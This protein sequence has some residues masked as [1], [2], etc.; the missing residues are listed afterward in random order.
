MNETPNA[1]VKRHS[2]FQFLRIFQQFNSLA[3]YFV[4]KVTAEEYDILETR[5]LLARR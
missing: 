4:T 1:S 5:I 2:G 3:V